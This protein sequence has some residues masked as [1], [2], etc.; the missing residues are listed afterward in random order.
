LTDQGHLAAGRAEN[1]L[2][3][4]DRSRAIQLGRSRA[5]RRV[6]RSAASRPW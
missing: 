6:M 3:G 4:A 1:T 2:R 5:R